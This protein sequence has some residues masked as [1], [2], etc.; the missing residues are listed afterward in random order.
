MIKKAIDILVFSLFRSLSSSSSLSTSLPNSAT[1][2]SISAA[3]E[4][5]ATMTWAQAVDAFGGGRRSEGELM[6][7]ETIKR[8]F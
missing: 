1:D 7:N 5:D 4:K 3:T 2:Y 8:S 6:N